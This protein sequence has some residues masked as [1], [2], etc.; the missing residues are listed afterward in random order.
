M[1]RDLDGETWRNCT[2]LPIS[3]LE[4][5]GPWPRASSTKDQNTPKRSGP[6]TL[7][8]TTLADGRDS[9]SGV[10]DPIVQAALPAGHLRPSAASAAA[11]A[12]ATL[13]CAAAAACRM[14][15]TGTMRQRKSGRSGTMSRP[16]GLSQARRDR[17]RICRSQ[18]PGWRLLCVSRWLGGVPRAPGRRAGGP[19]SLLRA[20]TTLFQAPRDP[21]FL[22]GWD[23][24]RQ[25]IINPRRDLPAFPG[26]EG[27]YPHLEQRESSS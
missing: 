22:C 18:G 12:A 6:R 11:S 26:Q 2:C 17:G 21:P 23:W 4:S 13:S 7:H 8:S 9:E 1:C 25:G 27:K 20:A 19:L 15:I 14:L 5:R 10:G 24:C 16:R 3:E